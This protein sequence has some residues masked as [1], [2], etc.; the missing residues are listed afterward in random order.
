M[1]LLKSSFCVLDGARHEIKTKDVGK[2]N[3]GVILDATDMGLLMLLLQ[4]IVG[5]ALSPFL[6]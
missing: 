6:S 5:Q 4:R 3:L 1:L 2:D